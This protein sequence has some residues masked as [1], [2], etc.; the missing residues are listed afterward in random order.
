M[1]PIVTR[2]LTINSE[3]VISTKNYSLLISEKAIQ[4]RV[5]E[6][7]KQILLDYKKTPLTIVVILKGSMIFAADLVRELS[8]LG[9]EDVFLEIVRV[10]SYAG[11]KSGEVTLALDTDVTGKD[12]IILEDIIDE[13][14]TINFLYQH[15]KDHGATSLRICTLLQKKD[16]AKLQ[17]KIDYVGYIIEDKFVVGYGLD[18]NE[19]YRHL[20]F[21]AVMKS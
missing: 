7:A 9:K 8:K 21:V 4:K 18:C 10:Y 5:K 2:P 14:K 11:Q 17:C 15:M 1:T 19:K 13:G 20:P 3:K 16:K 12:I 6:L